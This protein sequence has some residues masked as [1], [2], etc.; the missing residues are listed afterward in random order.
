MMDFLSCIEQTIADAYKVS[1]RNTLKENK[2]L[3]RQ[4]IKY[5]QCG[6]QLLYSFDVDVAK[7]PLPFPFF[8]DYKG[9]KKV[10][11]YILFTQRKK[12][13]KPFVLIFELK[14][15]RSPNKQLKL[16]KLFCDF[17]IQRMNYAFSESFKPE[18]RMIGLVEGIKTGTRIDDV[19]YR[20][21]IFTT[22][23]RYIEIAKLLV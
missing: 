12:D 18:I 5:K 7:K 6:K 11:D 8:K 22:P 21:G 4:E 17:L 23:L 15:S 16:T 3:G 14:K 20:D 2:A 19:S 9:L 10:S 1:S 13:K